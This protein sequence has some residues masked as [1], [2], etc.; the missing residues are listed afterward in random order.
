MQFDDLLPLAPWLIAAAIWA[1]AL[2][3]SLQHALAALGLDGFRAGYEGGPEDL[4]PEGKDDLYAHFFHQLTD[5]GFQ[6]AGVTWEKIAAKPRIESFAFLHSSESC[7]A[8]VWRLLGGDYRAYWITQFRDGGAVL[9][10]NYRRPLWKGRDYLARGIPTTDLALLSDNHRRDVATFVAAG[11]VPV[12]CSNLDE[13]TEAKR[14]YHHHPTVRWELQRTQWYN[15]L[16][17]AFLLGV[18]PTGV[19]LLAI[20]SR[21]LANPT[22]P[23]LLGLALCVFMTLRLRGL[24]RQVLRQITD[25][26]HHADAARDA[27]SLTR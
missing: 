12:R 9:T 16:T 27:E 19:A 21:R 4:A 18:M 11:S 8:S 14:A 13:V 1:I 2:G 20:A 5:L 6:P 10:T 3:V 23:W 22:V 26:Q 7:R 25:E 17:R 15:F 24:R